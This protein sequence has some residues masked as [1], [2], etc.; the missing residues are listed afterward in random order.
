MLPLFDVSQMRATITF[1]GMRRDTLRDG[2]E[3]VLLDRLNFTFREATGGGSAFTIAAP[4]LS[5]AA[6]RFIVLSLAGETPF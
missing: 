1:L 6:D 5:F 3:N 4:N 2:D